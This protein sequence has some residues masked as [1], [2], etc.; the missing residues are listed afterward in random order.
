M[1]QFLK[2]RWYYVAAAAVLVIIFAL[3]GHYLKK[4]KE[5]RTQYQKL[6]KDQALSEALK[7][8][9][10]RKNVFSENS[11]AMPMELEQKTRKKEATTGGRIVIQL[12]VLG[13]KLQN[14]MLNPEDHILLGNQ[15]GM[16]DI[17]LP[18]EDMAPQQCEIFL[19]HEE[20]YVR[21]LTPGHMVILQRKKQKTAVVDKAVRLLTGDQMRI[22]TCHVQVFLM[23]YKGQL[24]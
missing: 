24:M 14:Y 20:V 18:A 8:S 3:I 2:E 21:N 19:Y 17:V 6:L 23:D 13:A 22:G 5:K 7:N 9:R 16:N 15:E 12:S 10:S 4:R 11:Q 1:T